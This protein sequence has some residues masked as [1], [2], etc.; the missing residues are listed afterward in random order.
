MN[1]YSEHRSRVENADGKRSE[2]FVARS[3]TYHTVD[4]VCRCE[5]KVRLAGGTDSQRG[6]PLG[7]RPFLLATMLVGIGFGELGSQQKYLGGIIN[8]RSRTIRPSAA[9]YLDAIALLPRYQAISDFPIL[10]RT[11]V[12][13]APIMTSLHWPSVI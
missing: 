3:S 10:K 13:S 8:P 12:I 6:L 1:E 5:V 2:T 11:G 7:N 4:R 9:P